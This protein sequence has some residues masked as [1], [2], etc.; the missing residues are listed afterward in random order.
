VV[1]K[2]KKL[3]HFGK[4]TKKDEQLVGVGQSNPPNDQAVQ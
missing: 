2:N 4:L 3:A 1:P